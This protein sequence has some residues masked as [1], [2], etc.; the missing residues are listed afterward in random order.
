[1]A[2]GAGATAADCSAVSSTEALAVVVLPSADNAWQSVQ[3]SVCLAAGG[4]CQPP[5]ACLL[6]DALLPDG[7]ADAGLEAATDYV[8]T[9]VVVARI[10]TRSGTTQPSAAS[11]S[12]P[13][14]P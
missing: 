7:C 9:V 14:V 13:A 11:T 2:A 5:L 12:W 8:A 10:G 6:A 3:L 4:G 1:M